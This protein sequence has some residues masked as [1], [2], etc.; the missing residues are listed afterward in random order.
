MINLREQMYWLLLV[1]ESKLSR[2][3]VNDI[4]ALWCKQLGHSVQDFF[5][6]DRTEWSTTC[7]L[8]PEVIEKLERAKEK[9]A[10]Q[11]FIIEQLKN[12][13][14][15]MLTVLDPEYPTLLKA[16]LGRNQIPSVL[17]YAGDLAILQ[18]KTI[19]IVGS[20]NASAPS[21]A[22]SAT[23]AHYLAEHGANII[24][25]NAKGVDRSAYEGSTASNGCTTLVLPHG[26]RHISKIQMR[27][28]Q[29][30]IEAGKVLLLSQ[31]HPN[32]AW[33][34]SRAMERNNVITG[35]AQ[36]VI[37]AESDIK[38]GTW[39]GA[40]GALKQKRPLFVCQP[41][42]EKILPGNALLIERGGHALHWPTDQLDDILAPILAQSTI[43]QEQQRNTPLPP[44]QSLLF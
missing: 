18:R 33:L 12:D 10:G 25:G 27:D 34:V 13:N 36:I 2:R 43:I 42:T 4:L 15:H 6:A 21:L 31:F 20:R 1:F 14:I 17:F 19:A 29:P 39:E 16:A 28:L 26:I 22:F 3:T 24:S 40:N 7:Y 11:A 8:G 37:V 23:A 35:L 38:G 30:R 44:D 5:T 41:D 9:A 32:D